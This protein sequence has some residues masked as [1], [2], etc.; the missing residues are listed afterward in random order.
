MRTYYCLEMGVS[1]YPV[2][3]IHVQ[4]RP[5][6]DPLTNRSCLRIRAASKS[7]A[8]EKAWRKLTDEREAACREQLV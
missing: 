2:N 8:E 7:E 6:A 3:E 1:S 4:T 5:F